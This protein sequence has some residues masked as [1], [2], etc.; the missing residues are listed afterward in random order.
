MYKDVSWSCQFL[1]QD[2]GRTTRKNIYGKESHNYRVLIVNLL[3]FVLWTNSYAHFYDLVGFQAHLCLSQRFFFSFDHVCVSQNNNLF[4][5]I[6][7]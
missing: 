1:R 4:K 6:S 3:C 5:Q 7:V 2:R